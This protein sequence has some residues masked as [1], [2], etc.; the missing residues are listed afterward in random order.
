VD[1]HLQNGLSV[2]SQLPRR[3]HDIG[4]KLLLRALR[5]GNA[6]PSEA[7][8]LRKLELHFGA[9]G[10]LQFSSCNSMPRLARRPR[11]ASWLRAIRLY[12][13]IASVHRDRR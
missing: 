12:L 9:R 2:A 13:D 8:C 11:P 10:N 3:R 5:H 6:M 1:F 4:G 7:D